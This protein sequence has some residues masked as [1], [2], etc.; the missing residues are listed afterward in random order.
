NNR[1][2]GHVGGDVNPNA[3]DARVVLESSKWIMAELVRVF[4]DLDTIEAVN[5]VDAL[6]ERTVPIVWEVGARRRVLDTNLL[7]KAKTLRLLYSV[8]RPVAESELL[9]WVEPSNASAYRREVLR[10]AHRERLI[11]YDEDSG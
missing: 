1:G 4:H 7:M 2:V 9:S 3:M 10:K 8:G 5:V 6:V 11:E